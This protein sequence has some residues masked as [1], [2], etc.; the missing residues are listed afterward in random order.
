MSNETET[1]EISVLEQPQR[2]DGQNVA[3][4]PG[5]DQ[6]MSQEA[7]VSGRRGFMKNLALAVIGTAAA[8]SQANCVI[9]PGPNVRAE[10]KI[11]KPQKPANA[12]EAREAG[13]TI[14]EKITT[15]AELK[16]KLKSTPKIMLL[17]GSD[18][19]YNCDY[20]AKKWG[21]KKPF[22]GC[23]PIYVKAK[24]EAEMQKIG[25]IFGKALKML[26]NQTAKTYSLPF[27]IL[28]ENGV[29]RALFS[30]VDDCTKKAAAKMAK[31]GY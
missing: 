12:F 29:V 26:V 13:Q 28:I 23:T 22:N 7:Q 4:M 31:H 5:Q 6:Q 17:V 30:G 21:H 15:L 18:W 19:C 14:W 1:M 16:E 3:E 27:L 8:A 9:L 24:T 25:G 20:V 11:Q 2:A 10:T